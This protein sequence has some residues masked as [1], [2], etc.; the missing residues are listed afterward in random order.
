M[1]DDFIAKQT[2][3]HKRQRE[4]VVEDERKQMCLSQLARDTST[5]LYNLETE[6][7][8][9]IGDI[10]IVVAVPEEERVRVMLGTI[11]IGYLDSSDSERIKTLFE[12]NVCL[13]GFLSAEITDEADVSGNVKLKLKLD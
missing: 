8:V 4:K 5:R 9:S 12:E 10:V 3:N 2:K 11:P 7:T 6:E 1:G 13:G